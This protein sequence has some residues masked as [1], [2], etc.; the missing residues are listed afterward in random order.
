M[1]KWQ[2]QILEMTNKQQ[3]KLIMKTYKINFL[4]IEGNDIYSKVDTFYDE[5]DARNYAI[6][7]LANTSDE[8]VIFEIYE[9]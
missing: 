5:Q 6:H 4:D 8:C 3:N 7:K 9:L 2:E 1:K